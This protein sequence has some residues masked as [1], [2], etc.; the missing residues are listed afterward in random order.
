MC[1]W[2]TFF[3]GKGVI[4]GGRKLVGATDPNAAES[5][6]VRSVFL[7]ILLSLYVIALMLSQKAAYDFH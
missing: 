3:Q 7:D 6:S 4:A 2:I 5:G 1:I